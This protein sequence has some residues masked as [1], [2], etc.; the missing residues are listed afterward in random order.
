MEKDH[1]TREGREVVRNRREQAA[2]A[3]AFGLGALAVLFAVLNLDEVK[4]HW[5]VGTGSTPL[6]VVIAVCLAVGGIVGW[7]AARRRRA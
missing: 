3:L 7:V 1:G 2:R 6:I 5:I 4:V